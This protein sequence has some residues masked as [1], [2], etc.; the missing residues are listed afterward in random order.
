MLTLSVITTVP[1][2]I[3]SDGANCKKLAPFCNSYVSKVKSNVERKS[4][5]HSAWY[6]QV[7]YKVRIYDVFSHSSFGGILIGDY[8][9]L[10]GLDDVSSLMLQIARF[11]T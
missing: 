8:R 3:H 7:I 4:T 5:D 10:S 1:A 11:S 2:C 9:S 6:K